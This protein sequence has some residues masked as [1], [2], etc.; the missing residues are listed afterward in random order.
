MQFQIEDDAAPAEPAVPPRS[1]AVHD[2]FG[3]QREGY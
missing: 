2:D 3:V 1:E